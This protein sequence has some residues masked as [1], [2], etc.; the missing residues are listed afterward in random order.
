M[1]SH[2]R[3]GKNTH[4]FPWGVL[5]NEDCDHLETLKL[6]RIFIVPVLVIIGLENMVMLRITSDNCRRD[7]KASL[8]ADVK[9]PSFLTLQMT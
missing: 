7:R 9:I 2:T 4:P 3:R 8:G 5:G 1:C 6:N